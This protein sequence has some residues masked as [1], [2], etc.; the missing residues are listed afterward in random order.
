MLMDITEENLQMI[1]LELVQEVAMLLGPIM[2]VAL[3]AGVAANYLQVGFLFSTESIQFKLDKLDPIKGFKRIFSMRAV[4]ELLK[5]I[6][7][8]C[9]VG[10]LLFLSYGTEWMKF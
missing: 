8:I 6:L 10:S 7:K 1:F 4:V 9:I 3:V 5:S 2:L